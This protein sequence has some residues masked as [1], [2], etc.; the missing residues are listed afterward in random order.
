MATVIEISSARTRVELVSPI[1][2]EKAAL[3]SA[4]KLKKTTGVSKV[5]VEEDVEETPYLLWKA[6]WVHDKTPAR[7]GIPNVEFSDN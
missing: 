1:T 4:K 7:P 5:S 3:K 6:D 2:S